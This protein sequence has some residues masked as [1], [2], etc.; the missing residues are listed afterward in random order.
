MLVVLWNRTKSKP[1]DAYTNELKA[2]ELAAGLIVGVILGAALLYGVPAMAGLGPRTTVSD[3]TTNTL[4]STVTTSVTTTQ[5]A[6]LPVTTTVST[7]ETATST[8]SLTTTFTATTVIVTTPP[9]VTI[10]TTLELQCKNETSVVLSGNLLVPSGNG[11]GTLVL[12]LQ[13]NGCQPINVAVISKTVPPLFSNVGPVGQ[14]F[15]FTYGNQPVSP[16]NPLP[17][18]S[19]ASGSAD[20]SPVVAGSTYTIYLQLTLHDGSILIPMVTITAQ[21]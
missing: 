2:K 16:S 18:G 4:T 13:N 15:A 9:T 10:T 6:T 1:S 5:T 7:T 19:V 21:V 20:V 17:V 11:L 12:T 3:T 14:V 8:T